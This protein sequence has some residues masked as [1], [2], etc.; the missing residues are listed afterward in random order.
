LSP[1]QIQAV[2]E[3]FEAIH[4]T[5]ETEGKLKVQE[6]TADKVTNTTTTIQTPP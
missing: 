5:R 3:H 6:N 1:A 4:C 2:I